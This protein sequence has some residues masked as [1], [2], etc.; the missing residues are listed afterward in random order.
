[1]KNVTLLYK[2][3]RIAK[4]NK[5]V[6]LKTVRHSLLLESE[7]NIKIQRNIQMSSSNKYTFRG[8]EIENEEERKRAYSYIESLFYNNDKS[9]F[10]NKRFNHIKHKFRKWIK[11]EKTASKEKQL[12]KKLLD[13][14]GDV[15]SNNKNISVEKV[16]DN[17]IS[18]ESKIQRFNDK[19][20]ALKEFVELLNLKKNCNFDSSSQLNVRLVESIFKIPIRNK[21]DLNPD[22]QQEIIRKYFKKYFGDFEE[23]LS[24]IHLDEASAHVHYFID[25]KNS[26]SGE[27]DFVQRQYE[28]CLK[29][30]ELKDYPLKNSD[31]N[32]EQCKVIGELLQDDFYAFANSML[33]I[34]GMKFRFSQLELTEK[35]K[36]RREIIKNDTSKPIA[37]REYNTANYYRKL[38]RS[39]LNYIKEI[40][41]Q[42]SND[43]I[44]KR[45]AQIVNSKILVR[46]VDFEE[47]QNE[48][49]QGIL[50]KE[51]EVNK[52]FF[53]ELR[54]R[55]KVI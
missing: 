33:E 4:F 50:K 39:A 38:A 1:M 29:T 14:D 18:I 9:K 30:F 20:K 43:S 49:E 52:Y 36:E 42:N 51:A 40:F 3:F 10:D 28:H 47:V 19:E 5:N 34:Y 11:S 24:V 27:C 13:F 8:K 23:V 41:K 2:Q 46:N 25:A 45:K 22:I 54:S 32:K 21:V 44:A 35:E 16:I 7:A 31:L 12:F 17:F 6:A 55:K 15:I 37:D 53:K 48:V 26:Q